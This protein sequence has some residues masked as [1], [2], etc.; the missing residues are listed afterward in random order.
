MFDFVYSLIEATVSL[1]ACAGAFWA[2]VSAGAG[3]DPVQAVAPRISTRAKT[4]ADNICCDF[5]FKWVFS[6]L[7]IVQ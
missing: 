1:R 2:L 5:G 7:G 6:R 4:D 3:V